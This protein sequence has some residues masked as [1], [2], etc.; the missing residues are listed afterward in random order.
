MRT[1]R[2]AWHC[3]R[4]RHQLVREVAVVNRWYLHMTAFN[5]ESSATTTVPIASI[6]K[7]NTYCEACG[8]EVE[9]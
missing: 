7:E 6:Q 5:A 3:F 2:Q 9:A 1:L 4:G 8:W